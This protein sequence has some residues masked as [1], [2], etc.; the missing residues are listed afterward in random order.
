MPRP[1]KLDFIFFLRSQIGTN[2]IERCSQ[3]LE[4]VIKVAQVSFFLYLQVCGHNRW[5]IQG[6]RCREQECRSLPCD[7]L[8][9]CSQPSLPASP[10]DG[11]GDGYI[12][13]VSSW[14]LFWELF[15]LIQKKTSG[16]LLDETNPPAMQEELLEEKRIRISECPKIMNRLDGQKSKFLQSIR[17]RISR[18]D[19]QRWEIDGDQP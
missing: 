17:V 6:Q 10:G 3:I 15:Y 12:L 19:I 9:N 8:G 11:D 2:P 18:T 13:T 14:A 1:S 5:L 7:T 4:L 16:S